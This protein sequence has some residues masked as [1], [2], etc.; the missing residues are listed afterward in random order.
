MGFLE[1]PVGRG[2]QNQ[3]SDPQV[4]DLLW[5]L[6]EKGAIHPSFKTWNGSCFWVGPRATAL[7]SYRDWQPAGWLPMGLTLFPVTYFEMQDPGQW[8]THT[9]ILHCQQSEIQHLPEF[10][11]WKVIMAPSKGWKGL[12]IFLF[13]YFFISPL[14][15]STHVNY[16]KNTVLIEEGRDKGDTKVNWKDSTKIYLIIAIHQSK[17]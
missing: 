5:T 10:W 12:T 16:S 17:C 15:Y 1:P 7:A 3:A 11:S 2:T 6:S 13:F 8:V 4:R 14:Y 9:K